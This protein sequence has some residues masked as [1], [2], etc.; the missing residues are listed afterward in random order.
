[1]APKRVRFVAATVWPNTV[2]AG[3]IDSSTGSASVTPRP[4]RTVRRER[5]FLVMNDIYLSQVT[6]ANLVRLTG[7][8]DLRVVL[9]SGRSLPRGANGRYLGL[10]DAHLEWRAFDH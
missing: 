6:W 9:Y 10:L 2:A 4:W 5:R 8:A 1:M 3:I 7:Q